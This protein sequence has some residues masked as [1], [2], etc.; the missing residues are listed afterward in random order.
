MTSSRKSEEIWSGLTGATGLL[1]IAC[2]A[3]CVPLLA[4]ILA[5]AGI[6]VMGLHLSTGWMAV[7]A[8]AALGASLY[9]WHRR[10]SR[11]CAAAS[12]AGCATHCQRQ[13]PGK[14]GSDFDA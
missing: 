3:C 9:A 8:I 7:F 2:A 12:E 4:P 11:P 1:L 10:R 13:R 14:P 6:A 5:W